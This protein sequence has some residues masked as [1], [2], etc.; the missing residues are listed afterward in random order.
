MDRQNAAPKNAHGKKSEVHLAKSIGARLTLASGAVAG[1]KGD[2]KHNGDGFKVLLEA[3]STV[4]GTL[5]VQ[6]EWLVKIEKEALAKNSIPALAMSFVTPDGR[7]RP[8]GC[9]IAMPLWAYQELMEKIEK[10]E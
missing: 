4:T 6:Y 7:N 5:P 3:K 10:K 9:W 1:S 8:M 2:M